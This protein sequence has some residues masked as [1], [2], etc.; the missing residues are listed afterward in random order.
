[1]VAESTPPRQLRFNH[2]GK[3]CCGHGLDL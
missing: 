3:W 1:L 2:A